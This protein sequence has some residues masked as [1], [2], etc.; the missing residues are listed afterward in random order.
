MEKEIYGLPKTVKFCKKCVISN[1]KVTPSI[2]T[3]DS[4]DSMKNTLYFDESGICE[5]CRMHEEFENKIDWKERESKLK[6]LLDKY[7]SDD[8]SYD[9]I[10]PGS[11]GKDSIF[12]SIILK[13]KYGMH[14]LTVTWAPHMYT[15]VGR[16][17]FESWIHKGGFD[18][19]LFTPSGDVQRKLTRLAYINMLHPFQPFIFGQ[20]NFVIHMAKKLGLKLIFFGEN[21]AQY[22]GFKGE[23]DNPV[24]NKSYFTYDDSTEILISGLTLKELR[25]KYNITKD[26]LKYHLPHTNKEF[27]ELNLDIHFLGHYL[28]FHPQR[29]YYFAK[30][31]VG[32][33]PNNQRTDGTYS[34]YNSIDDKLDGFHYWTGYIKFG[35]G[36]TTH[37]ASQEVRNGDLTREEAV[38]L[39]HKYDGELPKTFFKDVLEYLDL[40]EKEFL[41][42]ADSFRPKHLWLRNISGKYELRHQLK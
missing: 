23:K 24:M 28:Q 32:F 21:P 35:V 37:E 17:N 42:I 4:K 25:E 8:G 14:P 10:V 30:E 3:K 41:E 11:G 31:K 2:V 40:D 26:N 27:E 5:P 22:G 39:V 34:R 9:C 7:R 12:Q 38:A 13:E 33:I 16:R 36:R 29:N 19:F 20:R 6:K 15:D 1:Q 18:N